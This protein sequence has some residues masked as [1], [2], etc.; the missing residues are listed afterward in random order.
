VARFVIFDL[1][2][3][4]VQ[5]A[6]QGWERA[7][8]EV[9]AI[10]GVEPAALLAAYRDTFRQRQV[11]WDSE[12]T[13]RILAERAGGSPSQGQ[14]AQAAAARRA[15][16]GK[17]LAGV[18]ASTIR[19]LDSVRGAG[20]RLGLVS[21]ASADTAESWPDSSLAAQFEVAVFS[22]DV[23]AAK[24][25]PAIYLAATSALGAQPADCYYV[26]DG[27]DTELAGAAALGMTAVRTIQYSDSDPS[28]HGLTITS[29][30][31]L[32]SL[33]PADAGPAP[34]S[35]PATGCR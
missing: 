35:G 31:G 5:G 32:T 26:G 28:W 24:P 29:L 4:L 12:L 8:A 13:M 21:N 17:V 23:G 20:Y 7:T 33:L 11:E 22:C 34:G 30:A 16:A 10:V 3:T 6:A 1:F 15:F 19:V 27:A 14:V 25:D 18:E 2:H 9:A